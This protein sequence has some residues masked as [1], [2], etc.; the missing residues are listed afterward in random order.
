VI[1]AG[2]IGG[3]T[4]VATDVARQRK[5][6]FVAIVFGIAAFLGF[7]GLI[8]AR[9]GKHAEPIE[10]GSTAPDS[11]GARESTGTPPPPPE[12]APAPRG[13]KGKICPTCGER[14]RAEATFCG[15]DATQLVP[16]N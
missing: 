15:K 6:T 5:Y 12:P 16:L 3:A 8:L 13:P 7:V 9:R 11:V 1:A 4:G 14:Y 10:R 2:S